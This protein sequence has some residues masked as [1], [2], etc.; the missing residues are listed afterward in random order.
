LQGLPEHAAFVLQGWFKLHTLKRWWLIPPSLKL[1]R[2][3]KL[4][5]LKRLAG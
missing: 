5:T 3:K 2:L 4:H 1:R